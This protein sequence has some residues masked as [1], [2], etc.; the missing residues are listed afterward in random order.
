MD[1][2]RGQKRPDLGGVGDSLVR[3]E[4]GH[5]GVVG[6][7]VEQGG[8]VERGPGGEV[9]SECCGQTV[10]AGWWALGSHERFLIRRGTAEIWF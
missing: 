1:K 3:L 5:H 6:A 10:R 4:K 2:G 9:G 8:G 7:G